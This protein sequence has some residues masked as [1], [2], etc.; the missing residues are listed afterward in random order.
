VYAESVRRGSTIV[1]VN[2]DDSMLDQAANI[3]NTAGAV[4]VDQRHAQYRAAGY[5]QFDQK[6]PLYNEDQAGSERQN[7]AGQNEIALPVVE[8]QLNVGKRIVQRGSVR[9]HTRIAEKPVS[10]TVNLREEHI[11]VERRPVDRAVENA[12]AAFQEGSFEV[13]EMAEV[14][15]IA[16][17]TRVVEEVVIGKNVTERQETVSDTVKRTEVEVNKVNQPDHSGRSDE[18]R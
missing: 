9:V 11:T 2:T 13:A 14:P 15:V 8:E 18:R 7:Y 4:N 1:T 12:P 16:K 17:E 5:Q 10:E 3:L 6:A